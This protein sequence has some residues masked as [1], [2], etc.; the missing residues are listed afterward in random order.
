VFGNEDLA[1]IVLASSI[2]SA[3]DQYSVPKMRLERIQIPVL[4]LHHEG[5]ACKITDPSGAR[6][7]VATSPM[8]L[9]KGPFW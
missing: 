2:T 3:P 1:G 8:P 5:D 4:V 9:S 6:D 7:I